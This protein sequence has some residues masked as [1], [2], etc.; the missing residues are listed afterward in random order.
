MK[1]NATIHLVLNTDQLQ[2]FKEK[3]RVEGVSL[4]ELCRRNVLGFSQLDNIEN[5]LKEILENVKS[6][7]YKQD[8]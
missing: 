4:S 3:A 5:L 2:K 6:T 8:N 1:S 7:S